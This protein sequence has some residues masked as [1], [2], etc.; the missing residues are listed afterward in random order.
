MTVLQSTPLHTIKHTKSS[1]IIDQAKWVGFHCGCPIPQ[2]SPP[3]LRFPGSLLTHYTSSRFFP[4]HFTHPA[5]LPFQFSRMLYFKLPCQ[6]Y[7]KL[8][9]HA[10]HPNETHWREATDITN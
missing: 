10:S 8:A 6:V 9:D 7:S 5:L 3:F 4:D 1:K 2:S